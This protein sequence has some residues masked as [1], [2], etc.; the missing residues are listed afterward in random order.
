[1]MA[2]SVSRSRKHV[3]ILSI[4]AFSVL[5]LVLMVNR[6]ASSLRRASDNDIL[7]K[8]TGDNGVAEGPMTVL[9]ANEKGQDEMGQPFY[10]SFLRENPPPVTPI[11][12][13][14][15]FS[16]SED[17]FVRAVYFDS[18]ARDGHQN[19]SVFLVVCLRNITADN[20]IV[21]CLVDGMEAK[22]FRVRLIGETPLWRA[23]YDH[24]NHE[25]V[26]VH[27]YDLPARNGSTGHVMYKK[28][29][30]STNVTLAAAERPLMFP[31]PRIQPSSSDGRKYNMTIVSCA[32]IF[33]KPPWL[34]EWLT[35]QRTLGV[36]HVHL[37]AEDTFLGTG[38]MNQPY[39]TSLL[40]AGFL[41]IDIWKKYL[42]PS[43]IWYHNQGLIYEDC[44]YR[45]RGTYDYIVMMD[46]DDFFTPRVPNEPHLHYYIDKFCRGSGIG[47]CKFKWVEYYPDTYGFN[48][49]P[50]VDG[51]IT[52]G[53]RNY[54]HYNQGNPKS[55]HRTTVLIDTATHYAFIMIPG[56]R[57]ITVPVS[58]AY[59][60]H[61]R[62]FKKAPETGLVEGLPNTCS[63]HILSKF[64]LLLAVKIV[65]TFIIP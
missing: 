61:V 14:P 1:M 65:F 55:L 13:L 5:F 62:L 51:N 38:L 44:P 45:F 64:L 16:P 39:I 23:F 42:K 54:A 35:Y 32:K 63:D 56:Y 31:A 17:L 28:M 60:A 52:R 36:D 11:Y 50:T 47:S 43:Q 37:D 10:H 58:E 4:A 3:A 8:K 49:A 2:N 53:L 20:L 19:V 22:Q 59:V 25:E 29:K 27:C 12:P 26:L 6:W 30:N 41:S 15:T 21:G 34:K 48:N 9:E 7:R 18:R 57:I 40:E 24:I 33:G 46:T